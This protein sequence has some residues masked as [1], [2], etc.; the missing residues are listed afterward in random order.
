VLKANDPFSQLKAAEFINEFGLAEY[1]DWSDSTTWYPYSRLWGVTQYIGT[2][3]AAIVIYYLF[4]IIGVFISLQLAAYLEPAIF[5][6]FTVYATYLLGKELANKR[7]GLISGFFIAIAPGHIQ[8]SMVGFF[9]NEALGVFLLVLGVYLFVKSLRTGSLGLALACGITIGFLGASWGGATFIFQL[10]AL[11]T[12]ILL[13]LKRYS[14]RLLIAYGISM[15]IGLLVTSLIPRNGSA[16]VFST[17]G[18]IP[19]GVLALLLFVDLYQRNRETIHKYIGL[20]RIN[21]AIYSLAALGLVF[22]VINL[23]FNIVPLFSAKFISVLVPFFRADTPIL[24]SVAE[25]LIM[26]WGGMFHNLYFLTFLIPIGIL[27]AYQKPTERNIF[28][29]LFAFTTLYF[30][31]SMVRLIL[32][33]SP[34]AALIAAKAIDE[35]LLPFALTYQEKFALSKRKL[36]VYTVIGTEHVAFAYF[37][38]FVV[39]VLSLGYGQVIALQS[40]SPP[41]ILLEFP[42]QGGGTRKYNDWFEALA[43]IEQNSDNNDVIV[44]W[45]DYGYWISVETNKTILV[46]NATINSTQIGNVGAFM[47]SNPKE[48]LKIARIYDIT[49]AVVLLA[50]GQGYQGFD[51]DIGKCQWMIKIA[52]ASG[53]LVELNSADYFEYQP[54]TNLISSYSGKFYESTFWGMLTTD[55][56]SLKGEI[57]KHPVLDPL[58]DPDYSFG[59]PAEYA[60]YS[61]VFKEAYTTSNDWIRI[62]EVDYE[63]ADTLGV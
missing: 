50:S 7:V 55:M 3:L 61:N 49:Y 1:F 28:L 21:Q 4:N 44:S 60:I 48:S 32:I 27:Y 58:N 16:F 6:A 39:M 29:L 25:H 47:M 8:R 43:W 5:G 52:E 18:L 15:P 12:F 34:A 35:T 2:P 56:D 19:L 42:L 46:D 33:L 24:K 20:D 38:I 45:W 53:N 31:A 59:W 22:F 57:E 63:T 9:D 51:N 10:L 40:L 11:Y 14:S 26:T 17:E 37:T 30:S 23:I 62:F 36:R 54:G 13:L 41:A